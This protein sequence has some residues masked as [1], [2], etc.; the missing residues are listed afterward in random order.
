MSLTFNLA[1]TTLTREHCAETSALVR[2]PPGVAGS[3]GRLA[4]FA[5]GAPI[6]GVDHARKIS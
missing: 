6:I 3:L 2:W 5:P 4:S 1:G